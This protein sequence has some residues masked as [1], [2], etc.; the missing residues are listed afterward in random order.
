M[1]VPLLH[2]KDH[3]Q[4]NDD[5]E[6]DAS[7]DPSDLHRMVRVFLWLHSVRFVSGCS[8]GKEKKKNSQRSNKE[9]AINQAESHQI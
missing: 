4:E 8:W 9:N 5:E 6:E 7:N 1:S 2:E 3:S